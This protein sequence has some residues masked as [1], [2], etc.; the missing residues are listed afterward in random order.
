MRT[1][2]DYC[3][4]VS[5]SL[6]QQLAVHQLNLMVIF[7][8]IAILCQKNPKFISLRKIPDKYLIDS[9]EKGKLI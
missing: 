8:V 2:Q 5:K 6:W 7:C 3:V 1:E 4:G 9:S